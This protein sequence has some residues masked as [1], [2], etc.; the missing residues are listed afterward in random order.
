MVST[1]STYLP[2]VLRLRTQCNQREGATVWPLQAIEWSLPTGGYS[3]TKVSSWKHAVL[4][5]YPSQVS[6]CES[7]TLGARHV[8]DSTRP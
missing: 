6:E 2:L 7:L 5:R 1:E 3:A 4:Y 8:Q